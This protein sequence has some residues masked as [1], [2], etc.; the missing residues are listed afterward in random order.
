MDLV[1]ELRFQGIVAM[2][3]SVIRQKLVNL[4]DGS[5]HLLLQNLP[6]VFTK[7]QVEEHLL[8]LAFLR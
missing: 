3:L 4:S 5:L 6:E 7:L 2:T 8:K 1:L